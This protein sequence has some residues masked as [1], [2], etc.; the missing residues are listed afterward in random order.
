MLYSRMNLM[1]QVTLSH[2]LAALQLNHIEY[3]QSID[4]TSNLA[5]DWAAS[6]YPDKS[7]IVAD[8]QTSGRGRADHHWHTPPNAAIA[9]S[10]LLRPTTNELAMLEKNRLQRFTGLGAL[11][12]CKALE[13][14]FNISPKIKW[15]NDI[16]LNQKKLSG[17][18][19]ETHW[20][21][22]ELTAIVIGIGINIASSSIPKANML[23]YPATCLENM[24]NKSVDRTRLIK[25]ILAAL[26]QLRIEITSSSFISQW[27]ERLAWL[28]SN[29]LVK[30]ADKTEK[31]AV[32][33]GLDQQGRLKLRYINGK[34]LNLQAEEVRIRPFVD[35]SPN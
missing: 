33:E 17:V 16:L 5:A 24:I 15:P 35:S 27:E 31:K 19:V 11:A 12:V 9:L 29:V 21:G 3:R 7:L 6:E 10:L 25:E 32:L 2:E 30:Q 18:L 13:S 22:N 20:L 1:D 8:E 4:S 14:N 23:D 28:N 34:K 26:L